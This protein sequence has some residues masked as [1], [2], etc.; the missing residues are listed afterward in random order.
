MNDR[1]YDNLQF[2]LNVSS[3]QLEEWY[4]NIV[5]TGSEDDIAYALELICTARTELELQL[6]E[7]FDIEAY[8][9]LSTAR[10]YL[11]KFQL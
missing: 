6:L 5:A 10:N 11:K 1:D 8:Q 2:L 3:D 9:D 4:D 7:I